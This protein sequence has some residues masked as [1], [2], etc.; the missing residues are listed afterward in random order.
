[1]LRG[2]LLIPSLVYAA[3]IY[4]A[5]VVPIGAHAPEQLATELY[6]LALPSGAVWHLTYGHL[7]VIISIVCLFFELLKPSNPTDS[8]IFVNSVTAIAALIFLLL[9]VLV[10]SFGT[11]EF[12][13]IALMAFLDFID[14]GVELVSVARRTID[15]ET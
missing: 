5:V 4:A 7:I 6:S 3:L 11:S 12:F 2:L 14:G 9:F 13:L 10:P 1:M 8:A 15:R